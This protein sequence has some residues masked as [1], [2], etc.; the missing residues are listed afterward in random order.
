MPGRQARKKAREQEH[1][2]AD[3]GKDG[4]D[5]EDDDEGGKGPVME[6]KAMRALSGDPLQG[7]TKFYEFGMRTV[8]VK[9]WET[10]IKQLRDGVAA[11]DALDERVDTEHP[12]LRSYAIDLDAVGPLPGQEKTHRY[13]L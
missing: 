6:K 5:Q 4:D 10:T 13:C 8:P 3:D 9:L 11:A 2:S 12:H 7:Q 1:D